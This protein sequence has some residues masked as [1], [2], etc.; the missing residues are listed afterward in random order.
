MLRFDLKARL[1]GDTT[2]GGLSE[3]IASVVQGCI[4]EGEFPVGKRL[5]AERELAEAMGVSRTSV[6]AAIQK[7]KTQGLISS[8]QGGGTRV[9]DH[10]P[11]AGEALARYAASHGED[12][13]ALIDMRFTLDCWAAKTAIASITPAQLA[14]MERALQVMQ[15]LEASRGQV[16]QA[17]TD[18]RAAWCEAVGSPIFTFIDRSIADTLTHLTGVAAQQK[19]LVFP[20]T[21]LLIQAA[22]DFHAALSDG[23]LEAAI[24]AL[25][26]HRRGMLGY[27]KLAQS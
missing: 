20:E 14:R 25:E 22:I 27:P 5:P 12:L 18:Y 4:E 24:A 17:V 19:R 21:R 13:D 7:L 1:A 23:D 2:E 15:D 9:A 3:R 11:L 8:V 16:M 26:L 10:L 6:R